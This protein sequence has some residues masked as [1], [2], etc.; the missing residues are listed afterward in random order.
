MGYRAIL[1][2]SPETVQD[3][4][5]AAQRR[6]E[7]AYIL[8]GA[9]KNHTA[10][11]IAGLSAEM[12]LKTACFFL[13]GARP[14]DRIQAHFAPL[15]SKRYTPPFKKDFES[16]HGLW[17]WCQELLDRRRRLRRRRAPK[18]FRQVAAGIYDDWFIG[19]RYRPGFATRDD[20]ASF[21]T[22]VAWI[23]NNHA[24]LRT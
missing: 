24:V 20:A 9:G 14:A 4:E 2:A 3:M 17:F 6:L 11:Y 18:R 5:I 16:G 8:F 21:L 12:Y 1:E 19:M 13:G 23:A 15:R 10:I 22:Q 7:E